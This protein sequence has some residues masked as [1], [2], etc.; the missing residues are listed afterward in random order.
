M[1]AKIVPTRSTLALSAKVRHCQ[2]QANFVWL[3]VSG[4]AL[5]SKIGLQEKKSRTGILLAS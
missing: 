3:A 2:E 4:T 1:P 5:D